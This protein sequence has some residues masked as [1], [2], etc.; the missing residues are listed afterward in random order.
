MIH[1]VG[2]LLFPG[3][4]LLDVAGPMAVFESALSEGSCPAYKTVLLSAPGGPTRSSG[5]VVLETTA[6][7][8]S[9]PL[10]TALLCGGMGALQADIDRRID[11]FLVAHHSTGKRTGSIC[12][13][14]F[15]LARAGLLQNKRVTTHWRFARE[16]ARR[17]PALAIDAERIWIR[18]GVLWTSAGVTAGIDLALALVAEDLGQDVA[19]QIAQELV[20]Y[21]QRP[22]GQSQF[23]ALLEIG[24]AGGRFARL[25]GWV[26]ACGFRHE[27]GR[28]SDQLPATVPI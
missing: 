16:L 18:D 9:A 10:D 28:H 11:D 3:F 15:I 17:Y 8:Q 27:A 22:G 26:R 23:S 12:T 2:L 14:A 25:L 5:G 1:R 7:A 24:Q 6:L 20:V 21:H 19:K 4:Q 13:G